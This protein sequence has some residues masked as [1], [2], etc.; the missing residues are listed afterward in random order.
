MHNKTGGVRPLEL[1]FEKKER[2]RAKKLE[3][4][5]APLGGGWSEAD[6]T[7]MVDLESE[8]YSNSAFGPASACS[9]PP[10]TMS[11][12]PLVWLLLLLIPLAFWQLVA[13]WANHHATE[14]GVVR[15]GARWV[16]VKRG[17]L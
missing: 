2:D 11:E 15:K 7:P 13:G 14:Q 5:T 3:R 10:E 8:S 6:Q 12:F 1:L 16:P 17:D 9:Q 4:I